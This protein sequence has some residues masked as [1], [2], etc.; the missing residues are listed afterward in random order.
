MMDRTGEKR[1]RFAQKG[2]YFISTA[3]DMLEVVQ[4]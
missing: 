3:A 2:Y 1:Q 4:K